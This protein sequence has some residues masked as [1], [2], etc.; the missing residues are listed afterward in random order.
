WHGW[1]HGA[2][3]IW[4]CGSEMDWQDYTVGAI[5]GATALLLAWRLW[6]RLCGRRRGGCAG[7]DAAG[8]P[9]KKKK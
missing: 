3:I 1:R 7:C 8:C 6:R 2:S 4:C 5:L 9:L